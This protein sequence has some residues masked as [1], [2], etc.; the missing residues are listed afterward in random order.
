MRVWNDWKSASVVAGV[1]RPACAEVNLAMQEVTGIN[2]NTG[3]I[4]KAARQARD[5]KG[6]L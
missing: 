2:Y 6:T 5:W 1:S 3:E 4:M